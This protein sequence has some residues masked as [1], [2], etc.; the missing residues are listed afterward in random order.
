MVDA[1]SV[2]DYRKNYKMFLTTDGKAGIAVHKRT[3]NVV[4]VFN[5]SGKKGENRMAKLI[6]V[7]IAAGGRRLDFFAAGL[8]NMYGRHGGQMTGRV[9]FNREFAPDGWKAGMV[10]PDVAMMT[11]P[12]SLREWEK[13]YDGS[14]RVEV[15]AAKLYGSWDDMDA[16][17]EKALAERAKREGMGRSIAAAQGSGR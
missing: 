13:A 12:T 2:S 7:A 14:R 4:S 8:H 11:L 17:T 3:G 6:P 9:A 10:E 5:G 16:A 15:T 1:H